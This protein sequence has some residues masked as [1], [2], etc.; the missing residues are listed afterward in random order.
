MRVLLITSRSDIG[1]GPKHLFELA[2]QLKSENPDWFLSIASPNDEPYA[3]LF[4][5]VADKVFEIPAR[6]FSLLTFMKLLIFCKKEN[7]QL[8][9]SHGRGAGIYS[10]VLSLFSINTFHTFHGVHL[11]PG[12]SNSLKNLVERALSY[13]NC[14]LIFVSQSEKNNAKQLNYCLSEDSHVI[15]N[16]IDLST[17]QP[18]PPEK[19]LNNE[20]R[21]CVLSRL[22][23][24]KNVSK[25]L[26]LFAEASK[27][28][29]KRN[30]KLVIG[31][32]GPEEENLKKQVTQLG[33]E[34]KV[35][36]VVP[37]EDAATF[38]QDQDFYL[39]SSKS[40]GMPYTP[41]EAMRA[42]VVPLL[43]RVSGHVDIM[44]NAYLYDLNDP[45][46]F[47][48]KLENLLL[49]EEHPFSE[50]L[51]NRFSLSK[52]IGKVISLYAPQ[53]L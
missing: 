32:Y 49:K 29:A 12:L 51:E 43:S 27:Y 30:P 2:K 17:I 36:F 40:E 34:N 35:Q 47:I 52:Q 38:F 24:H 11:N 1:G 18:K 8:I 3:S 41:L 23:S 44:P 48:R 21:F 7:I 6:Q 20:L 19:D 10:R 33:L 31:G 26:E 42:G 50:I 28:F 37:I 53:K 13:L 46:D 16:G 25:T 39:S 5:K 14:G 9:H 45:Q 22:D 15:E 4:R